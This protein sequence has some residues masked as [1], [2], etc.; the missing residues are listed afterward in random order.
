MNVTRNRLDILGE[1]IPRFD[2]CPVALFVSASQVEGAL[3][4]IRVGQEKTRP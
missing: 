1:V 3:E 2:Q 4:N